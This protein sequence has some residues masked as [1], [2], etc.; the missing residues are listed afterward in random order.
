MRPGQRAE[1]RLGEEVGVGDDR[2]LPQIRLDELA[3]EPADVGL[4]EHQGT[5]G[6]PRAG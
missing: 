2:H 1:G 5:A 3:H 6:E 4:G